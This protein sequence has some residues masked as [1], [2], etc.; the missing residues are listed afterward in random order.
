MRARRWMVLVALLAAGCAPDTDDG[1]GGGPG[2]AGPDDAGT[3]P[4]SFAQRL[5]AC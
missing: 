1:G 4:G 5:A 3:D 2:D